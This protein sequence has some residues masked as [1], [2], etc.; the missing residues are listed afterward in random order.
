MVVVRDGDKQ[1]MGL[2]RNGS[3]EGGREEY[4]LKNGPKIVF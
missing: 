2:R 3:W 1:G 4:T